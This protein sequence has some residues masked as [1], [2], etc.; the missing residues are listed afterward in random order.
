MDVPDVVMKCN[1]K[2]YDMEKNKVEIK[3]SHC[4][5]CAIPSHFDALKHE[6]M[7]NDIIHSNFIA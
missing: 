5:D 7:E 1:G 4:A 6:I 3:L 2:W